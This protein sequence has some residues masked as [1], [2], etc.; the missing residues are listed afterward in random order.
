MDAFGKPLKYGSYRAVSVGGIKMNQNND[1][2]L[3]TE[4]GQKADLEIDDLFCEG[5]VVANQDLGRN[6]FS[7][8]TSTKDS[9]G[10]YTINF[11]T[12]V[13]D[14]NYTVVL[15]GH[16]ESGVVPHI[17]Q[18]QSKSVT[19]FQV[20]S[21][22]SASAHRDSSFDFICVKQGVIFCNGS[23]NKDGTKKY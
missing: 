7:T 12:P 23:I 21:R 17:Y 18:H 6:N 2:L 14:N 22:E 11:T 16:F 5:N 9:P 1:R 15:S 13:S 20:I 4:N 3:I 10:N 8:F 19:G